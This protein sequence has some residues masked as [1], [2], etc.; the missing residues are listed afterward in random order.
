MLRLAGKISICYTIR[1][2]LTCLLTH[3]C[4]PLCLQHHP[5]AWTFNPAAAAVSIYLTVHG[6]SC[7]SLR[8]STYFYSNTRHRT[9]GKRDVR[10]P[11]QVLRQSITALFSLW[12]IIC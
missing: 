12:I 5:A 1:F 2:L 11:L 10:L 4:W 3:G 8:R 9:G 6:A 7:V